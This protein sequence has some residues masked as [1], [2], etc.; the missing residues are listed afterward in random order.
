VTLN[1]TVMYLVFP[2]PRACLARCFRLHALPDTGR[3]AFHI[4]SSSK[5]C[6]VESAE[7]LFIL[8]QVHGGASQPHFDTI[9]VECPLLEM[10]GF[11]FMRM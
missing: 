4:S 6:D 8:V 1:I 11:R 7:R 2:M 9:R 5:D 10:L 3:V